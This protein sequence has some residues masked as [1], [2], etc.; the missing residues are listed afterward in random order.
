MARI[1]KEIRAL[2]RKKHGE[3]MFGIDEVSHLSLGMPELDA[4][5][6]GGLP[7]GRLIELFGLE[8]SG[9]STLALELGARVQ[10]A[11]E[12]VVWIDYEN[13]WGDGGYAKGI[14]LDVS[15]DRCV[16]VRPR[17]LEQGFSVAAEIMTKIG[18]G[19]YVFDSL[20]AATPAA[21][22]D[23]LIEHVPKNKKEAKGQHAL[24]VSLAVQGLNNYL[25]QS[26]GVAIVINQIRTQLSTG[27]AEGW[28]VGT[29]TPGGYA[30]KFYAAMRWKLR[31]TERVEKDLNGKVIHAWKTEMTMVKSK[32][33]L[34]EKEQI[35]LWVIP[36]IGARVR[37][38]RKAIDLGG[39]EEVSVEGSESSK[40]ND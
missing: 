34:T 13:S 10:K 37:I 6:G 30:L 15:E 7:R 8:S 39:G 5:M 18:G 4:W 2:L 9:K 21:I 29:T 25:G 20:A 14:G 40:S 23:S 1:P 33:S 22:V 3:Q 12:H 19:L 38:P 31:R 16:V 35:D 24:A 17:T 32:V 27:G 11:G 36:C 28:R 26:G